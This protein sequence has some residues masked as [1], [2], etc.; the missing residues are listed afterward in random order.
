MVLPLLTGI[1]TTAFRIVTRAVT[2]TVS[3]AIK[4]VEA[5]SA[6][7]DS[8][9][10]SF[11]DVPSRIDQALRSR[12]IPF[13]R[14][15]MGA[16]STGVGE[17]RLLKASEIFITNEMR[18]MH[19]Y[20]FRVA[21]VDTG[22][23]RSSFNWKRIRNRGIDQVWSF[24]VHSLTNRAYYAGWVEDRFP[25]VRPGFV[26]KPYNDLKRR[27]ASKTLYI[28]YEY[29]EH[30]QYF[31]SP[32]PGKDEYTVLFL[33]RLLGL[34]YSGSTFIV[35]HRKSVIVAERLRSYASTSYRLILRSTYSNVDAR[36]YVKFKGFAG[37]RYIRG[38][39]AKKQV[40]NRRLRIR[41]TSRKGLLL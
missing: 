15:R 29:E 33:I 9:P 3:T 2:Y 22:L 17:V 23:M 13:Y 28:K 38:T 12:Q 14:V 20:S 5:I 30:W 4:I 8:D 35:K 40:S 36:I 41:G 27:L 6:L 32:T 25:R 18:R 16:F 37:R 11:Y 26:K 10:R 31:I 24:S 1:L 39:D 21:N 34:A 7:F 19:A